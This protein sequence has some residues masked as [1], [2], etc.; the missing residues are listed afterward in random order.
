MSKEHVW[1]KW[2]RDM[3][4]PDILAEDVAQ[5]FE[6]SQR[7]EFRRVEKQLLFNL[8]VGRVCEPCNNGWMNRTEE[9]AEPYVAALLKGQSREIHQAGQAA[10]AVWGTL[11][12]FVARQ[13]F[14]SVQMDGEPIMEPDYHA[15][16]EL[17][18]KRKLPY[19]FSVYAAKVGWSSGLAPAGFFRLNG[20]GRDDGKGGRDELENYLLTFSVLDLAIFILRVGRNERAK[21]E[22]LVQSP[23]LTKPLRRI[24]PTGDSFVG[25]ADPALTKA[26]LWALAG[27]ITPP[28]HA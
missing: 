1:P 25:L 13:S 18:D 2:I 9:A 11:K 3:L 27:G 7:G 15:L 5:V 23:R 4:H 21:I 24:W 10:V 26:G 6:D 8:T 20:V 16:Y 17:R 28:P 14:R 19:S 12:A 22:Q